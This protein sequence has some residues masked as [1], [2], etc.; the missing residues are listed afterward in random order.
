MSFWDSF[1]NI[2]WL[3]FWCFAF[4]A[5]LMALFAVIVDL[6]RDH[7]LNGWWK[8]L[9]IIFLIFLPFITVLVYVI[10]RGPGMNERAEQRS[11]EAQ[12]ATNSYIREVAS[13]S[14]A[15]EIAKAKA[16]LDNGTITPEEYADLKARA[17][18]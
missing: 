16:L 11:R 12:A 13:S 9:W 6:F 3:F 18:S 15:D 10:A 1:W 2:M 5:Y 4:I 8:A 14:S 17:M 7:K